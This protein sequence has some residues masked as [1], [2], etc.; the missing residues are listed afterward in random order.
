MN[1]F[2]PKLRQ[3]CHSDSF[4]HCY[5]L[6]RLSLAYGINV[7]LLL[8]VIKKDPQLLIEIPSNS[9]INLTKK[10]VC[11]ESAERAVSGHFHWYC[12]II[13]LSDNDLIKRTFW[14]LTLESKTLTWPLWCEANK[15]VFTT[16]GE[17]LQGKTAIV[18]VWQDGPNMKLWAHRWQ[19]IYLMRKLHLNCSGLG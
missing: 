11:W 3:N 17:Q 8:F 15:D 1:T 2:Y 6:S 13:H 19:L 18:N 10:N 12:Q 4:P 7:G 14:N 16:L 5:K 9:F